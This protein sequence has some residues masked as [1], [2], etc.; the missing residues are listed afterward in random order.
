M[1]RGDMAVVVVIGGIVLLAGMYFL[2][3]QFKAQ[4][5]Q[6]FGGGGGID[7]SAQTPL[8]SIEYQKQLG[9]NN[10]TSSVSSLNYI[11][12]NV[13][14]NAQTGTCVWVSNNRKGPA[15]SAEPRGSL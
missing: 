9:L 10:A 2:N 1:A 14:C 4:I 5:D 12:P 15:V 13:S 6:M 3:P 8:Q 7:F 11:H